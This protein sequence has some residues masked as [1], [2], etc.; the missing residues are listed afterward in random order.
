MAAKLQALSLTAGDTVRCV[1]ATSRYYTEGREYQVSNH[2]SCDGP[3]IQDDEGD[4]SVSTESI[5]EAIPALF[6]QELDLA[7]G[8]V[9]RCV[10]DSYGY[11]TVGKEYVVEKSQTSRRHGVRYDDGNKLCCDSTSRFLVASRAVP[12]QDDIVTRPAH[13]AC[14]EIEPLTFIM[15]NGL[16]FWQGNPIKYI[17]RAG[18]KLY[19]GQ[20]AVQ[21]EITDLEKARRM[22]E[23][24]IKQLRGDTSDCL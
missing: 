9:V 6:I 19:P 18:K 7:V 16:S 11:F 20:D 15:R 13:Y 17:C 14:F 10:S 3:C 21:S 5:F 4:W 24:R 22:L 8:D 1:S 2:V 12:P 23:M